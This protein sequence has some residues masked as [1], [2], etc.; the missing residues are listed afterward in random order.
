MSEKKESKGTETTPAKPARRSALMRPFEEME[1]MYDELMPRGWM[2]PLQMDWLPGRTLSPLFPH[3]M[4]AV[5]II[6]RERDVLVRA[7]VPGVRKEDIKVSVSDHTLTIKGHT[8]HEE[9]EKRD[10]Y[11]R[12]ELSYGDFTRTLELPA[13]VDDA[14]VEATMK[15]GIL[16]IRLPKLEP[17]KQREIEVKA[18]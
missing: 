5:D 11:Y 1:R 18:H 13:A 16:E 6:D 2:R 17:A 9:E 7:E 3:R 10:D 8:E 15:N 14:K 12:H 4:P